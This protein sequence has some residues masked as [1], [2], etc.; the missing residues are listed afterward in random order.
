LRKLQKQDSHSLTSTLLSSQ[1]PIAHAYNPNYSGG[2]DQEVRGLKPAQANSS[3]RPYLEK[4]L[5]RKGL[6]EGSRYRPRVQNPVPQKKKKK[7]KKRNS[8]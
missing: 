3:A 4:N 7:E 5:H 2:S 1:A 6:V 8:L